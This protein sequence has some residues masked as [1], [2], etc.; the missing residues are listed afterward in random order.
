ME[1][2]RDDGRL[3]YEIEFHVGRT[4]YDYEIDAA[5]GTVLKADMDTDD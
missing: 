5:S 4:E 3:V 1:L 2:D